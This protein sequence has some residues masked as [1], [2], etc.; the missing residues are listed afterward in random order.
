M[1][2]LILALLATSLAVA[3][4]PRGKGTVSEREALERL[5]AIEDHRNHNDKFLFQALHHSSPRVVRAAALAM[6]RIGY[7]G[8]VDSLAPLA[9]HRD[10]RVREVA[11]FSL[12]LIASDASLSLL[13]QHA[14]LAGP[15]AA[16]YQAWLGAGRAGT[17]KTVQVFA[18]AW[19]NEKVPAVRSGIAEGLGAL[20]TRFPKASPGRG[21]LPSLVEAAAGTDSLAL[22]SAFA[23]SRYKGEL[24]D[25]TPAGA[26]AGAR[27]ARQSAAKALLVRFCGRLKSPEVG[28]LLRDLASSREPLGVR[29][30]V[31]MASES[32]LDEPIG[33]EI[34][35]KSLADTATSVQVAALEALFR[36]TRPL[37]EAAP[38]IEALLKKSPSTWVR[39]MAL[40]ALASAAPDKARPHLESAMDPASPLFG[41]ALIGMAL[42]PTSSDLQRLSQYLSDPSPKTAGRA[43]EALTFL[44][45]EKH[46]D[47]I[48]S[49][50]KRALL[51]GDIAVTA[52]LAQVIKNLDLSDFTPALVSAYRHFQAAD[53]VE[54]KIAV[55][56]ALAA[57]KSKQALP[58]IESALADPHRQVVVAAVAAYRS[59]ASSEPKR[60]PPLNSQIESLTPSLDEIEAALRCRVALKTERG[61]MTLEM[62]DA[63]PLTVTHFV[64]LVRK[65]FYDGKIFHRV[66][67]HFVAQG[68]DPRGDGYGGPGFFVRDEVS[69]L[70]HLPGTVGIA[71]AGKDTGGSQ[72]FFNLSPNLHLAGRYTLF[73]RVVSGEQ[74]MG[75]I[76]KGDKILSAKAQCAGRG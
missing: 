54:G 66:V 64:S 72:I 41:P 71:T 58:L 18:S 36:A 73:A 20:W 74:V 76:E 63:A 75:K 6:G 39:G 68:G 43:A 53:Q 2:R 55:L 14:Q 7:G 40:Q 4:P 22:P 52:M 23:L 32:F 30:E 61:E 38:D 29:E 51:L 31:A 9:T 33:L 56:D 28:A 70:P 60:P 12:G 47:A 17:E 24:A 37:P 8:F 21:L 49:A 46:T 50:M 19:R 26:A 57:L 16:R 62:L 3:A 45:E 13:T 59:T 10:I 27:R 65:G 1:T 5:Y 69:P 48:R 42:S 67:P 44:P 15:P 11:L 35:R 25:L 34:W